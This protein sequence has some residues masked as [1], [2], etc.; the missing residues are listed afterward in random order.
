MKRFNLIGFLSL[1]MLFYGCSAA[2]IKVVFDSPQQIKGINKIAVFPFV[3]NR[4]E[5]GRII[6]E[7]LAANLNTSRFAVIEQG[8]LHALLKANR[9][10][11]KRVSENPQLVVGQLKGVD[12]I[13][14]GDASVRAFGGY[15]EHVA[16]TTTRMIDVATGKILLEVTFSSENVKSLKGTTPADQIGKALAQK[17]SSY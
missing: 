9:L 11:L 12:A 13:I 3:C 1:F 2:P 15:S 6:A 4:S 8:Q 16:E 17:F 5:T 14:T 10:T 7:A